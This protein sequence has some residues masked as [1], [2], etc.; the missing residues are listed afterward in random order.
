M[1]K[2]E[3]KKA[4]D[5]ACDE[6]EKLT[7]QRDQIEHKILQLKRSIV[8]LAPL[9]GEQEFFTSWLQ[10]IEEVGITDNCREVLRGSRKGLTPLQ[11]KA[12][13]ESLGYKFKTGNPLAA[14]HA[15]LKRLVENREAVKTTTDDGDVAYQWIRRFPRLRTAR[16]RAFV[17]AYGAS[18]SIAKTPN[19]LLGLGGLP[20][21]KD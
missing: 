5:L 13:L 12:Q 15:V 14:I 18:R 7:E 6:L 20:K 16:H 2:E 3:F 10:S 19:N 11:V 8:A 17:G 1:V 21:K 4:L 9:A